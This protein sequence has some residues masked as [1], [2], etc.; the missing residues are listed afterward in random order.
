MI[1]MFAAPR[2]QRRRLGL[3]LVEL[4]IVLGVMGIV[5]AAIWATASSVK[6]RQT[7]QD[8]VQVV[9]E[10]ASNVRGVYTGFPNPTTRPTAVAAQIAANLYPPFVVN[11]AGTDT[12]NAWGGTIFINMPAAGA[13]NGFSIEFT[14]P[15]S[16]SA[17]D[18]RDVCTEM[19]SRLPGTATN[20]GG[21]SAGTLPAGAV[22]LGSGQ[23]GGPA[24]VY[25]NRG[26]W[27]NV[28]GD[29]AAALFP[30]AAT[31]DGFAFYYRL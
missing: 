2:S 13:L 30:A 11:A 5:A 17:V 3:S 12:V 7:V 28:T 6:T 18:R 23:G 8:T 24:L 29:A 26:G 14:L 15:A 9:T 31:C 27:A 1:K 25:V 19:V 22:D 20:Y 16:M 21:G 4:A 10:I